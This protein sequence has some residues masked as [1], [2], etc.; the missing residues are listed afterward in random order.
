M[1]LKYDN[2]QMKEKI[3]SYQQKENIEN[4]EHK[5]SLKDKLSLLNNNRKKIKMFNDEDEQNNKLYFSVSS[6]ISKKT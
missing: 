3:E 2:E 4:L 1:I 5:I 6:S